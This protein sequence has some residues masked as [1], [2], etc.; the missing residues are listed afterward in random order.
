MTITEA[1]LIALNLI[2]ANNGLTD[3]A[4]AVQHA[5][6]LA[7]YLVN[8]HGTPAAEPASETQAKPFG[9]TPPFDFGVMVPSPGA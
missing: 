8:P 4:L 9:L 3:P 2:A 6:V 5:E 7:R 1:R